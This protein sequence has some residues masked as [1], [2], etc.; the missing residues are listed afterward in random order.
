[1]PTAWYTEGTQGGIYFFSTLLSD[2]LDDLGPHVLIVPVIQGG[3]HLCQLGHCLL[4]RGWEV[5]P[6]D[7]GTAGVTVPDALNFPPVKYSSYFILSTNIL[8][9]WDW[10][11]IYC[12]SYIWNLGHDVNYVVRRLKEKIKIFLKGD[13]TASPPFVMKICFRL[14]VILSNRH[15]KFWV[16]LLTSGFCLTL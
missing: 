1:M 14:S 4:L 2:P 3:S 6:A 7:T 13:F 11:Q 5:F 9:W 12:I 8:Q 15:E 16:P 10:E